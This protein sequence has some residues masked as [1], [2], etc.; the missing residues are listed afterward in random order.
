MSQKGWYE[1]LSILTSRRTLASLDMHRC[2]MFS[3]R[4]RTIDNV[5]DAP[6]LVDGAGLL[7]Y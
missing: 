2:L 5:A 3:S 1:R 7:D 6:R 4:E